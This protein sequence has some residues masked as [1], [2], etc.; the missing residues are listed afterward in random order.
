[1]QRLQDAQEQSEI[2]ANGSVPYTLNQLSALTG[3]SPRS[4]SKLRGC[5]EAVDRQ[6]LEDFFRAFKLPLTP[7]DYVQPEGPDGNDP[8]GQRSILS[9]AQDWGE[10]LDTSLF[11]GRTE[12]L[13]TLT[14]WILQA[15]CRLIGVFGIG[16]IGKTA[17]S[18][19][20]AEQV[21]DQFEYV[22]WR[23]LRNAPPLPILLGELVPFLSAQQTTTAELSSLLQCLRHARCLVVLDNM[24]AILQTGTGVGQYRPGY[25]AYGALLRHIAETR[26]PSCLVLTSREKLAEVAQFE[27]AALAV[28]SVTLS[29][30]PE[31]ANALMDATG[32]VGSE[33][34][35]QQLCDRYR[36]NP[37]ALKI[38]ATTICE[39][40]GGSIAQFLAQDITMFGDISALIQQQCHR[41][42]SLEKQVILW[43][44]IDREWV[45]FTQLQND[46]IT[47]VSPVQLMEALQSLGRRSL[48]E[49]NCGLFTLQPVVMEWAVDDLI[50]QVFHEFVNNSSLHSLPS[51]PASS[52]LQTYALIKAQDEDYIRDSQIRVILSP[53]IAKLLHHLGS[54]KNVVY[55]LNEILFQ[56]RTECP[57]ATGYAGGN[58]IN[59]LRYLQVDLSGYDFSYLSI[60]QAD[61]Q[62]ILLH[63]VNFQNAD[64]RKTTFTQII[65]SALSVA[66]SP[67]SSLLAVGDSKGMVHIWQVA[68]GQQVLA[69]KHHTNWVWSVAFSPDGRILAS[70]SE[71]Q[72]IQLWNIATGNAVNRLEGHTDW[73]WAVAFSPSGQLLA[74]CSDDRTVRIWDVNTGQLLNLL[75]GHTDRVRSVAF[76]PDERILA[77]VGVDQTVRLWD[78]ATKRALT[79]LSGH[80]ATVTAV[81]FSADGRLLASGSY[82]QTVRIWDVAT[83]QWLRS[84]KGHDGSVLSIA[85]SPA[86]S[87]SR[88][89][90]DE[91]SSTH[92]TVILASGSDDQTV[93][94]WDGVT[95]QCLKLLQ[96]HTKAVASIAFSSDGRLLTSGGH[97]QVVRLWNVETGQLSKTLHGYTDGI[98]SI[99]FIPLVSHQQPEPSQNQYFLASGGHDQVIRIWDLSTGQ[100]VKRLHQHTD[101]IRAIAISP[102]G[103]L[104]ASGGHDQVIRI[105]DLS[106]GQVVKRLHQHTDWIRAIAISPDGTLL[107]SGSDDQTICLWNLATG[108]RLH[109]LTD[110]RGGILSLAFSNDGQIL[111]CGTDTAVIQL[112]QVETGQ[113]LKTLHGHTSWIW[114]V[115]FALTPINEGAALC[116]ASA[117]DDRTICLWNID[118]GCILKTLHG[119]QDGVVSVAFSPDGRLLA[120]GSYDHTVQTW[121]VQTGQRLNILTGHSDWV[122]SVAFSSDGQTIASGSTD[123]TLNIWNVASGECLRTLRAERPYEGM[124]ITGVTGL[125]DAQK[126][127]LYSLG[128]F[129]ESG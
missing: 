93:R 15:N 10:A 16:G 6:T 7:E 115:S 96:G 83:G 32:I 91:A 76:S 39:L 1:L 12:E 119:H 27:G 89:T 88:L 35:R 126:A 77:S 53:L 40:F 125:N 128:A 66:F 65:E 14:Q 31:A 61:L 30:S 58:L 55:R 117:S 33:L 109:V 43:L 75:T 121:D 59:L 84:L 9:V 42:S 90:Q 99:G 110:Y 72:T 68:T 13:A 107:A 104:L 37:L 51:G 70:A 18:I 3:L 86:S 80:T 108:E 100:V 71:D 49:I 85:F 106:T 118:T 64:F 62:N 112:W 4:I 52:L 114:S 46:L 74:S 67:D 116:L 113:L 79:I 97:D 24:E 87:D 111:A 38:V 41:L 47:A 120:S 50:N 122:R 34:Q 123:G 25:E 45:S 29:G 95:G 92:S 56:W 20:L 28:R 17:L 82:D 8:D 60:W 69:L 102:D 54:Q 36:C 81:A 22:I 5:K 98:Q 103:T 23:S 44:A 127:N 78:V 2:A 21:Q 73:I 101:W 19:K 26:H 94:I 11:Y 57:N 105:W 48:I 124:N 63:R 129:A